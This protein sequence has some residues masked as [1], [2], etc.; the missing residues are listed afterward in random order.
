M[1]SI[2]QGRLHSARGGRRNARPMIAATLLSCGS[3]A[4]VLLS[5][6]VPSSWALFDA[7]PAARLSAEH[8][9]F[10][11]QR[12][13]RPIVA[14]VAP[15]R[16]FTKRR[17]TST[18]IP[19]A[20]PGTALDTSAK[21]LTPQPPSEAVVPRD[22]APS[23]FVVPRPRGAPWYT[24]PT[25][26]QLNA[27]LQTLSATE[28]DS[29]LAVFAAAFAAAAA[30]RV[31]TVSERDAAAKEAMLKM[32]L[33]G[34]TLLVPPDNTGGLITGKL[35]F[36]LFSRGPSKATRART[37]SVF[38]ENRARLERLRQRADSLRRSRTDAPSPP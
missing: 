17:A 11:A 3:F 13:T 19:D 10:V 6:G 25:P 24:A 29:A 22:Y 4:A 30:R 28:R 12:A 26:R 36:S 1:I 14:T 27:P 7:P 2:G 33:T 31:P 35:P 15:A 32:R 18:F 21:P 5:M 8:V 20:E 16:A 37:D 9:A 34:R 23:R 38:E